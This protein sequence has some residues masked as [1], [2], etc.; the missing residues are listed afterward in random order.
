VKEVHSSDGRHTAVLFERDCGAT[1]GFSTQV[2]VFEDSIWPRATGGGNAFVA[3]A[4]HRDLAPTSWGGPWADMRWLDEST[5][6]IRYDARSRA[7]LVS[8]QVE[9]VRIRAVAV[10]APDRER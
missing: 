9:D 3:D 6:E 1:T 10:S 7:F 5:L 8:D 2:S 4:G